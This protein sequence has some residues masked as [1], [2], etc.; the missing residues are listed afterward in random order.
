MSQVSEM[1]LRP[2]RNQTIKKDPRGWLVY[3][4]KKTNKSRDGKLSVMGGKVIQDIYGSRMEEC[5]CEQRNQTV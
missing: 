3:V 5:E 4:E 1:V 2:G